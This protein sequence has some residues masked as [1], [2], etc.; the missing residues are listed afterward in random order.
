MPGPGECLNADRLNQLIRELT[1]IYLKN[2]YIHNAFVFEPDGQTLHLR[3]TEGRVT[4][5]AGEDAIVNAS[6][7]FPGLIGKPLNIHTL[8]QGLDHTDKFFSNKVSVDVQLQPG[9][10]IELQL[11]NQ[12]RG[13]VGGYVGLDNNGSEGTGRWMARTGLVIDSPFSLS[14][15]IM[16][17]ASHSLGS[18]PLSRFN[19]S[20]AF[21]YA[22]PYGYWDFS[23]FGSISQYRDRL[24]VNNNRYIVDGRTWQA[25][26]RANYVFARASN[27]VSS[28]YGQLE[29]ISALGRFEK[30][31]INLQSPSMVSAQ[32]GWTHLQ[33]VPDGII[34]SDVA[35][36][37]GLPWVQGYAD[38]YKQSYK[39]FSLALNAQFYHRSAQQ[40]WHHEHELLARYSPHLLPTVKQLDLLDKYAVRGFRQLSASAEKAI[41]LRNNVYLSQQQ[42]TWNIRPYVGADIGMQKSHRSRKENSR[43]AYSWSIGLKLNAHS[44]FDASLEF[45]KGRLHDQNGSWGD[46]ALSLS[47]SQRF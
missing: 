23:L 3:V 27:Y 14:D 19:R 1:A 10:D 33:V 16:F 17:S 12:S 7:L 4:R 24:S 8:D 2:G 46:H 39:S 41:V 37:Q 26:L 47:L 31:V 32:I 28:V 44:G 15:S 36:E 40:I 43:W 21:Q 29:R 35:Y 42:G 5:I 34:W 6:T 9:G 25:G 45:S 38:I 18:R 30:S 13:R 11:S 20:L 22:V